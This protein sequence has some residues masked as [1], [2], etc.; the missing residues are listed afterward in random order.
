M[1]PYP[2]VEVLGIALGV[3]DVVP[4]SQQNVV[5]PAS[6]FLSIAG[7]RTQMG[8]HGITATV[9]RTLGNGIRPARS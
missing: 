8:A 6:G 7:V 9:I 5:D 1:N 4:V 2:G 3:G